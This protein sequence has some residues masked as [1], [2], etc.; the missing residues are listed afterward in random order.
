MIGD[1][2]DTVKYLLYYKQTN[3]IVPNCEKIALALSSHQHRTFTAYFDLE[4]YTVLTHQ[5]IPLLLA[6]IALSC[7]MY[8]TAQTTLSPTPSHS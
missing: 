2:R 4:T 8:P 5:Q 6:K 7:W 1:R 3:T